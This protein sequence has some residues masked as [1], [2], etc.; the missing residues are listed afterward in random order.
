MAQL[1]MKPTHDDRSDQNPP[2][3][4]IKPRAKWDVLRR[5]ASSQWHEKKAWTVGRSVAAST[6]TNSVLLREQTWEPPRT[7]MTFV[8]FMASHKNLRRLG[9]CYSLRT[10]IDDPVSGWDPSLFSTA[11]KLPRILMI[12]SGGPSE[13]QTRI[14]F[15][16]RG[17]GYRQN[18]I[19]IKV[20]GGIVCQQ[21]GISLPKAI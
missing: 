1:M 12:Y 21:F 10:K 2:S 5:T 3:L 16:L 15:W 13:L 9:S 18:S 4:S 8:L 14:L 17:S 7:R 19:T 20:H 6:P 11:R